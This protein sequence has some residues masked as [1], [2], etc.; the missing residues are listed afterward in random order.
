MK[1]LAEGKTKT[2]YDAG[3][4]AVIVF[5]RDDI[6][7]GDGRKRDVI[8]GKGAIATRTTAN[9]FGLLNRHGVP[10]HFREQVGEQR[11]L[12]TRCEMIP[13]EVTIR[14]AAAGHYLKRHPEAKEGEDLEDLAVDVTFKDDSRHDPLVVIKEDGSWELHESERPV[15]HDTLMEKIEPLLSPDEVK[16]VKETARKVFLVLKEAWCRLGVKMIDLKIEFGRTPDGRIVV[17]DV[18]DNDSWRLWPDGDKRRQLD[19]EIYREG[20]GLDEVLKSYK[21]VADMTDQFQ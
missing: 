5:S 18:I 13:L 11:L 8:E 6:S 21:I 16:R 7:A 10:T 2:I 4:D 12:C 9:I 3:D 20:G 14:G 15:A 19:K 17:G 1:K